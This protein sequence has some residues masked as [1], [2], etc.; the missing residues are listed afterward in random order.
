MPEQYVIRGGRQGYDRLRLLARDRWPDTAALLARAGVGAGMRCVDLGCGGGEVTLELAHLVGPEGSATGVDMDPVKL[1]LAHQ[2]AQQRAID[3]VE[4][5]MVDVN[6]WDEPA[7]YDVVYTRFL[8]QHLSHPVELLARMW[9]AVRPGGV[10]LVEDTDFDGWVCHPPNGGFD[11]FV[12]SY[13]EVLRRRGGDHRAGLRMAEHF[14]ACG[15]APP[16]VRLVQPAHLDGDEKT[17]AWSTLD[18]T[19]DAI[20]AEH[21]ASAGEVDAALADLA[22]FTADPTTL[23]SGPRIFQVWTRRAPSDPDGS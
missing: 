6:G 1:D 9:A 16:E 13:A 12:R 23:V 5:R 15:I 19:R 4:F 18:A 10:L 21:V 7:A 3:N 17:L 14:L 20:V 8:L 22:A 11:F 2:E